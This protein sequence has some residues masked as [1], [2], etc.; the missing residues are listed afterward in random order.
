MVFTQ[1]RGF[2]M[3]ARLVCHVAHFDGAIWFAALRTP[4]LW[5]RGFFLVNWLVLR[6]L[7]APVRSGVVKPFRCTPLQARTMNSSNVD[8]GGDSLCY[9]SHF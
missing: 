8:N 2:A 1:V 5:Q 4:P 7:L 3:G 9:H 6:R